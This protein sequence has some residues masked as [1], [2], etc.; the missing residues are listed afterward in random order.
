MENAKYKLKKSIKDLQEKKTFL[1]V[2]CI[3]IIVLTFFFFKLTFEKKN[4][5]VVEKYKQ[6][7]K[8]NP[9]IKRELEPLQTC[10]EIKNPEIGIKIKTNAVSSKLIKNIA[11]I[12][13][14]IVNG[15]L[16]I[17]SRTD[18]NEC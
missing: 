1:L 5:S 4:E 13:K 18:K 9:H 8:T 10:K 2:C 7:I 15:S 16:T 11:E 14:N 12:V 3:S 17:N 6:S